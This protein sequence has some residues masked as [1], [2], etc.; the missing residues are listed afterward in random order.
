[1]ND[2]TRRIERIMRGEEPAGFLSLPLTLFE[3]VNATVTETRNVL[4][5]LGVFSAKRAPCRVISVGGLT[6]GGSGKTPFTRLLAERL[7]AMG[8]R[9]GVLSRGYGTDIP[10]GFRL[11]SDGETLAP[12][13]P[14]SPDEPY[15]LARWLPGVPVGCAPKRID[16]AR[17]MARRFGLDLIVL[18]DGFQHRGLARDLDVVLLDGSRPFGAEGRLAPRGVL[19]E[20][21]TALKRAGLIALVV[22][23]GIDPAVL[24]STMASVR[25]IVPTTPMTVARGRRGAFRNLDGE[26]APKPT[27][28]V[29]AFCGLADPSRFHLSCCEADLSVAAF[30]PFPDHHAYSV[31]DCAKLASVL[32]ETGAAALVTTEKDA[33]RLFRYADRLAGWPLYT[34]GYELSFDDGALKF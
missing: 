30:L 19:R 4:Y 12:P 18:D 34:L 31:A 20:A 15:L 33:V 2:L 14:H 22:G 21:P 25:Q 16:G 24:A 23:E 13:P 26:R 28:P 29:V 8:K 17:I 11:I 5:D 3:A 1:M 27:G 9:V 10:E 6:V 7:T 32:A